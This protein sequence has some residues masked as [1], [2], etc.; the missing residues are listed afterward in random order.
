[1]NEEAN[2]SKQQKNYEKEQL[3]NVVNTVKAFDNLVSN[4]QGLDLDKV[5]I[6]QN[7]DGKN[8]GIAELDIKIKYVLPDYYD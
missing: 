4:V 7:N 3:S 6:I 1:M 8:S 5:S 2:K